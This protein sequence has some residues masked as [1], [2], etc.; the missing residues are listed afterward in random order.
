MN[1]LR[2]PEQLDIRRIA[3]TQQHIQAALAG[4]EDALTMDARAVTRIDTAGVQL[5]ASALK[6][7]PLKRI[8]I[9][10]P[11][12]CVI[13]AFDALGLGHLLTSSD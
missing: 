7:G 13:A 8:A 9:T 10:D 6:G 12:P 5:L 3:E 2:L 4:A 1:R 11:A